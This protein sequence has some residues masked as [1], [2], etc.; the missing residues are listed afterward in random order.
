MAFEANT[1]QANIWGTDPVA[2]DLKVF[3]LINV[4][5]P[6][7][8]GNNKAPI[9]FLIPYECDLFEILISTDTAPTDAAITVAVQGSGAS[10]Q[11]FVDVCLSS[12]LSIAATDLDGSST[13]FVA[14]QV[15]R[16]KNS[17]LR[18]DIDQVGST[19]AGD[20]LYVSVIV[21]RT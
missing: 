3:T 18:V 21:K 5:V 1:W 15:R 6:L 4:D 2:D 19:I 20:K 7:T 16:A 8:T 11:T 17:R 14:G 12:T 9:D 10:D 13:T